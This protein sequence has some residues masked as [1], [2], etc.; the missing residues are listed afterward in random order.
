VDPQVLSKVFYQ[1]KVV[2]PVPV[3]LATEIKEKEQRYEGYKNSD[4]EQKE[5]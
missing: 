2:I 4:P 3:K 1:P 5:C